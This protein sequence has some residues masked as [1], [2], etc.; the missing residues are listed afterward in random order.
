MRGIPEII[1]AVLSFFPPWSWPFLLG[2]FAVLAVP[3]WFQSVR[4]KQVRNRVRR[5]VRAPAGEREVHMAVAFQLAAGHPRRLVTLA[6]EA[7]RFKLEPIWK[8]ALRELEEAGAHPKDLRLL[9]EKVARERKLP[10]H[11]IEEAV[12]IEVM[13]ESGALERAR[14]RLT[15]A[16]AAF[17]TDPD[18]VALSERLAKREA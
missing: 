7:I 2:L 9:N 13:I 11:P 1:Q 17:P 12:A 3:V 16:L 14:E 6:E 10:V 18:L 4:I 8:R 15:P 5:Y